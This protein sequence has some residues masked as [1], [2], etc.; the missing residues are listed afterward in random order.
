MRASGGDEFNPRDS[1]SSSSSGQITGNSCDDVRNLMM[2]VVGNKHVLGNGNAN[3]VAN[4]QHPI[5]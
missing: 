2:F 1:G 4:A 3:K 5:R